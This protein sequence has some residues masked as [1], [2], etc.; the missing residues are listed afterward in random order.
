MY[1]NSSFSEKHKLKCGVPQGPVLGAR[2]HTMYT[3][4][5]RTPITKHQMS[6]HSYTDGTQLYDYCDN[7]E[8]SIQLAIKRLEHCIADVC[9]WMKSNALKLNEEKTEFKIFGVHPS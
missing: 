6:Y 2:M 8:T 3:E 4:Q 5:M 1:I 9:K 7:D